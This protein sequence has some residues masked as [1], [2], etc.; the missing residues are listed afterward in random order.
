MHLQ[1]PVCTFVCA[2]GRLGGRLLL[3]RL[4]E[5]KSERRADLDNGRALNERPSSNA[6]GIYIEERGT[7]LCLFYG[8]KSVSKLQERGERREKMKVL[9]AHTPK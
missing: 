8:P 4:R 6:L 2:A 1:R 7:H 5:D 9:C 3:P